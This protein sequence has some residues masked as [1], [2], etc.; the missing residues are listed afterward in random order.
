MAEPAL[1][2]DQLK[3]LAAAAGAA[4]SVH[5]S[6]PWRLRPT[7]DA[8]RIL[9]FGDPR[10]A[11]AITDP[12]G[13]AL[14]VSVGAAVFNLRVGA[15]RLGR[16]A[17][18]GLLPDPAEPHLLA[19]IGLDEPAARHPSGTTSTPRS[20]IVTPAG[21]RSPTATFRRPSSAS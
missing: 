11:V 5:N 7:P 8:R 4:P 1:T 6:Q 21:S 15:G 20:G 10:R 2:L 12:L 16:A 9:V 3:L 18:V 14:H 17:S 19:E 13:R